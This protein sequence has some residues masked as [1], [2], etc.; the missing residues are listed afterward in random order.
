MPSRGDVLLFAVSAQREMAWPVFAAAVDAVFVPD[1]RV[2]ADMRHARAAVAALG[3]ELAHWDVTQTDQGTRLYIAPP[4]L[5]LLPCPGLPRAVLCGSR[6]PDTF[7]AVAA[8]ARRLG[9]V[10][11]RRAGQLALHPFAPTRVEVVAKTADG[12]AALAATTKI[13]F[14]PVPPAWVLAAASCCVDDYLETLEWSP[15][16]ELNWRRRDF[17]TERLRFVQAGSGPASAGLRLCAYEHPSGWAWQDRLWRGTQSAKVDRNWGRYAVLAE[18]Q[19]RLPRYDRHTG[20]VTVPRQVPLPK[21]LARAL[22]LSSGKPPAYAPGDGLGYHQF[23]DVPA[24]IFATIAAK[25]GQ[26]RSHLEQE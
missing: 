25:L 14:E 7:P 8:A 2:G 10:E 5:A 23:S 15:A 21:L 22:A 19:A 26:P 4:V 12:I 13:R 16:A 11:V 3:D 24:D 9:D 17:D 18:S 6:S 20:M 1:E